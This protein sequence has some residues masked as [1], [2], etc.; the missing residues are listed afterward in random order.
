M[1]C[2]LNIFSSHLSH[3]TFFLR[4][5]VKVG[6]GT[7]LMPVNKNKSSA[8]LSNHCASL[9][10]TRLPCHRYGHNENLIFNFLVILG[11][12][13]RIVHKTL[14]YTPLAYDPGVPLKL[15]SRGKG[16]P[17]NKKNTEGVPQ[18]FADPSTPYFKM[19]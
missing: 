10:S 15:T 11:I 4:V 12:S 5:H 14:R 9:S 13:F 18:K 17:R 1:A 19:E 3:S 7:S 2:S 6:G 16:H 8:R